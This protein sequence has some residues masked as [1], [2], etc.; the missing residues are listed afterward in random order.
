MSEDKEHITTIN[1]TV[2]GVGAFYD[3]TKSFI[4][5]QGTYIVAQLGSSKYMFE[6]ADPVDVS[7]SGAKMMFVYY[8]SAIACRMKPTLWRLLKFLVS[9]WI[10]AGFR[11]RKNWK[12]IKAPLH[13]DY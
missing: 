8:G 13:Y 5:N 11:L 7:K 6:L 1:P 10:S 2:F 12:Y 9:L 3:V 4:V